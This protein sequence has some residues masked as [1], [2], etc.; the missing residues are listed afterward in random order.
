MKLNPHR[1]TDL[2]FDTIII[3]SS[4]EA[5]VTA[6]KYELPIFCDANN[7]PLAHHHIPA[8]LDLSNIRCQNKPQPFTFLGGRVIKRGMQQIE[9]WNIMSYRLGLMGL[10]P[11]GGNYKNNFTD[12]IPN[13]ETLCKF[14]IQSSGKIANISAKKVILFDYPKYINGKRVYYVNDY[15]NIHNIYNLKANIFISR[16]CDFEDTLCY[17]TVFY[18][19][20]GKLH[21]CCA[22]SIIE[23]KHIDAWDHSATTVRLKTQNTIFWNFEKNF[24]I[25]LGAR[26]K[27]PM[28][29]KMS[30]SLEEIIQL[31]VMDG[32]VYE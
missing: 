15:I 1:E 30:E 27:A 17:E 4:V 20:S 25:S 5:M 9:L 2:S 7:K 13:H 23:E 10:M 16:D 14:S 22:K 31:N 6:F 24:K 3:G 12:K 11:F 29:T 21:N 32:E 19:Q 18:K 28:L 8:E 26:E